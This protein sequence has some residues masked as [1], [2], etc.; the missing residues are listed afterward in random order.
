M[1]LTKNEP[2]GSGLPSYAQHGSEVS[3]NS[4]SVLK[5]RLILNADITYY[6]VHDCYLSQQIPLHVITLYVCQCW[7]VDHV[8]EL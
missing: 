6:Q 5:C 1:K 4:V 8:A 2:L 3:I 7:D